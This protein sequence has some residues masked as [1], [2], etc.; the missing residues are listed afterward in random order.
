MIYDDFDTSIT[1]EEVY[2]EPT[3]DFDDTELEFEM[4]EDDLPQEGEDWWFTADGGLTADAQGYLHE[5]DEEGE[6]V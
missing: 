4:A 3:A 1:C 5:L 6:F 2:T